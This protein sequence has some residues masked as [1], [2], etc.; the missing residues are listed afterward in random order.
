VAETSTFLKS[1]MPGTIEE[2]LTWLQPVVC[3]QKEVLIN[4]HDVNKTLYIMVAGSLQA[5]SAVEAVGGGKSFKANGGNANVQ[6]KSFKGGNRQSTWK[7]KLQVYMIE[8][9]GACVGLANPFEPP[10]R[11]PFMVTSLKRSVMLTFAR[12]DLLHLLDMCSPAQSES[13]C[14]A[15]R[16]EHNMILESLKSR[17][18]KVGKIG[19]EETMGGFRGKEDQGKDEPVER[20]TSLD[21]ARLG[22]LEDDVA[23]CVEQMSALYAQAKTIPRVVA[24]LKRSLGDKVPAFEGAASSVHSSL[25]G[26]S[27]LVDERDDANT[28]EVD[29]LRRAVCDS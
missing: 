14:Q 2:V 22:Q 25:S 11:L 16:T 27:R 4:G 15:L 28:D 3:L 23:T 13:V 9:T 18:T 8:K 12:Q 21:M 10:Q 26:E 1:W 29:E 24:S 20:S 7:Q 19:K 5:S 17:D 6:P